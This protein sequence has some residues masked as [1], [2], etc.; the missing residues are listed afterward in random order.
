MRRRGPPTSLTVSVLGPLE[1]R[2]GTTPVDSKHLRRR[3]VREL[4][5]LLV[6][7]RSVRRAFVADTLWPDLAD[8]RHNL[9]VTINYLQQ[10]VQPDRKTNEAG[11]YVRTSHEIIE[12]VP[13]GRV[14]SDLWELEDLLDTATHAE[15]SGDLPAAIAAYLAALPLWRGDPHPELDD[16]DWVR[17]QQT[18]LRSRYVSAALR[19]GELLLA[20]DRHNDAALAADRA[21]AADPTSERAYQVLARAHLAAG[22][23]QQARHAM[24][25]CNR[26]LVDL[27][28]R[29]SATTLALVADLSSGAHRKGGQ[30]R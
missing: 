23:T 28:V 14:R 17:D 30:L 13:G 8:P 5:C 4:L 22:D 27:G 18:R 15:Q 24:N 26:S 6:T 16:L 19:A 10:A 12:L 25:A 3:R 9:R 21:S 29:P 1:V 7:H 20:S 11:A 2:R